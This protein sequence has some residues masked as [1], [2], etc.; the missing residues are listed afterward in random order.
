M[1]CLAVLDLCFAC[2]QAIA[3]ENDREQK[4]PATEETWRNVVHYQSEVL[5]GSDGLALE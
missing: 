1:I 4:H 2:P 3:L 5:F